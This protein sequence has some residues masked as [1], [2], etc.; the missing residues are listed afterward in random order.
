MSERYTSISEDI[1]R[2]LLKEYGYPHARQRALSERNNYPRGGPF[3]TTYDLAAQE[4]QRLHT[5]GEED[6]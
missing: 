4:I 1:A 2:R 5:E 6:V 3:W